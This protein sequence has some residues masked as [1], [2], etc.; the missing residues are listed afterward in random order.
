MIYF[1]VMVFSGVGIFAI[2]ALR[3]VLRSRNV[4]RIARSIK[5]G[6][7]AV[8]KRNAKL[9]PDT[10]AIK[11]RR[12]PRACAIELQKARTLMRQAERDI[13]KRDTGSAERALIQ[14]LT[15]LPD[16][17]DIKTELARIYL[18]TSREHKAEALYRDMV[19]SK[20]DPAL[21]G[22]LGLAC[23]KQE[24]YGPAAKAY[25]KA[26]ELD[27]N[28]PERAYDLGRA[29]IA[30]HN[31]KEA[32]PLLHKAANALS[33]DLDLLHLLAQCYMQVRD[34]DLAEEIYRRI[35]K[36]DP[37]DEEVKARIGELVKMA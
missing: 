33:R 18:E 21:Y 24:K 11:E 3:G 32:V 5:V 14:A 22:N 6:F 19:H 34:L 36:L 10:P 20:E 16:D 35:N 25:S 8:E 31:F 7:S 13:A 9:L 15:L 4:R 28:N 26:L 29:Y 37:R 27:P 1:A 30:T 17:I 2:I 12:N 23:Y